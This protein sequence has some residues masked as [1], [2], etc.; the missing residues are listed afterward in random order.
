MTFDQL[1]ESANRQVARPWFFVAVLVVLA[2]WVPSLLLLDTNH[3]DL[4]ID[5]LTNPLSVVLLA[6]LHNSR[7]RTEQAQDVRQDTLELALAAMM[8]HLADKDDTP[9][10][11]RG[12][13]L[14][15]ARL[16]VESAREANRLSHAETTDEGVGQDIRPAS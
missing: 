12:E 7:F 15:H 13:L 4:L 9:D 1:S 16:L 6:L 3:A 2:A 14:Q 5:A 8:R 11:E 10:D